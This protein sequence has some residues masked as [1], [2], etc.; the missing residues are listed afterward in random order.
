MRH[1]AQSTRER[2]PLKSLNPVFWTVVIVTMIVPLI[3]AFDIGASSPS[4]SRLGATLQL[5][6]TL[7]IENTMYGILSSLMEIHV[8]RCPL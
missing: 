6:E 1:R 5:F 3:R 7:V 4:M 8:T 2:Q